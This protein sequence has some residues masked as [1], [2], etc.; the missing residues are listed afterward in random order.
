M[1]VCSVTARFLYTLEQYMRLNYRGTQNNV[2]MLLM[3]LN[4]GHRLE[5]KCNVWCVV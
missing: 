1:S 3:E 2:Y 5:R 4:Y